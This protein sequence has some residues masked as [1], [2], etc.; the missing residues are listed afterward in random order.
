MADVPVITVDGPSGTG[1]GTISGMI[2]SSL[3]WHLLDSGALYRVLAYSAITDNIGLEDVIA[4]AEIA[5]N[6][7]VSFKRESTTSQ[8]DILLNGADVTAQVRTE[9]CGNAASKIAIYPEVREALLVRQ[10]AFRQ[11]PGL[12]ADG[13]DMGTVVFPD[14]LLKLF[15]TATPEERANRRHKQLKEQ[16]FSVN[17]AR[18]SADIAERDARDQERSQSPLIPATGAIVIDTTNCGV[19]QVGRQVLEAVSKVFPKIAHQLPI[20]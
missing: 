1:K 19:E 15:L 13:R 4:L 17:L 9:D 3:K 16:G 11:L 14:A 2:A 7:D 20:N 5:A 8:L 12:I 10:Q 6:L 18:L